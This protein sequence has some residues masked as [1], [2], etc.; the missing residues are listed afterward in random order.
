MQ[1]EVRGKFNHAVVMTD[2]VEQECVNQLKTLCSQEV[3]KD[4]KIRIMPDCH[5]GKGCVVGFTATV[6]D[7]IIPNLVGV[8][9]SCSISTYRLNVSETDF[10]RLDEVI[11]AYVPSGRAVRENISALAD[12]Q[13]RADVARVCREIG[14]L[15]RLE[16]HL[17]SIGSFG[18]RKPLFGNKP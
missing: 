11:R 18:G 10:S 15:E 13:L 16:R 17:C 4:S 1:T 9:I 14:D 3:F 12:E 5:A 2:Q 8:D 6:K 7:K